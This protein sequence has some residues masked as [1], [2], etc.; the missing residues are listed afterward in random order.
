MRPHSFGER[1]EYSYLYDTL[2]IPKGRGRISHLFSC[3]LLQLQ[4]VDPLSHP[5]VSG[6]VCNC[7]ASVKVLLTKPHRAVGVL[8]LPL[9]LNVLVSVHAAWRLAFM[10]LQADWVF[11]LAPG[12]PSSVC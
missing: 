9:P 8:F 3:S 11:G 6:L 12:C 4:S 10:T 7:A 5:V 1:T 2:L